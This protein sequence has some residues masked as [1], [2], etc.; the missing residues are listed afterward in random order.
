MIFIDFPTF[1]GLHKL[2][3]SLPDWLTWA[4]TAPVDTRAGTRRLAEAFIQKRTAER[5]ASKPMIS[6]DWQIIAYFWANYFN[7]WA[8]HSE[9]LQLAMKHGKPSRVCN[10]LW[11]AFFGELISKEL[12]GEISSFWGSF[13]ENCWFFPWKTSL[14]HGQSWI[15][16][17]TY[18]ILL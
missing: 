18:I 12:F 11:A 17:T 16:A 7:F 9:L 4:A 6:R 8:N 1:C 5:E 2:K 13:S 15:T 10:L 3:V 14:K